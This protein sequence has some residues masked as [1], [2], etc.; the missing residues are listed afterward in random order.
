LLKNSKVNFIVFFAA[1]I[2]S[3]YV[4]LRVDAPNYEDKYKRHT[5]IINNTVEY[6]YKYRL[7]NPYI[8]QV[9]F[10]VF[11]L[12]LS[13][14]T[15]FMTAYTMQNFIVFL[16]L[17][18]AVKKFFSVWFD[19]WG[20]I[21]SLLL[22]AALIPLSLTGYDTLGDMT[23][24]GL[25][26]LGFYFIN[27]D[28]I[29]LLYPVVFIGAFNE[30]QII[31]LI[32]FYFFG[33]KENFKSKSAW[34]NSILLVAAFL[35]AYLIIYFLRGG[36]A[37]NDEVVWYFTKDAAFNSANPNFVILW[38]V[39]IL[40]L[41]FYALKN[42]KMKPE[43]LRRNLYTVLPVF[44][45]LVFFFMARMREIDKALTIF[46][47]LIPLAVYSLFPSLFKSKESTF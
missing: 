29:K 20:T 28:K 26:A 39:M 25:M 36:K 30:F 1:L 12:A 21:I 6:P 47:I 31:L 4:T 18:F 35:F 5:S 17:F 45:V 22:F 9:Y 16:F 13:E 10:T 33:K 2:I 7:V 41:L 38:A 44:Y 46:L 23:T 24:A 19:E 34:I 8:A 3:Y 40:P 27:T 11:K 43:F 37:G 42:I 14:K 32:L 15:A